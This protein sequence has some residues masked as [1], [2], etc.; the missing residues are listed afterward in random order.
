MSSR[1][2]HILFPSPSN[3]IVGVIGL[4][5][6]GL[7]VAC[8]FARQ[9]F[10]VIGLDIKADRVAKINAGI[11]PIEGDEPGLQALLCEVIVAQKLQA[12]T[13]Y[14]ELQAAHVITINVETPVDEFHVPQYHALRAAVH[15][16]GEV[17]QSDTLV[18][19]ESTV[20]P[21]TTLSLVKEILEESSNKKTITMDAQLQDIQ[22]QRLLLGMCPERV[23]PGRL[24]HNLRNLDRVC[25][26]VTP[27]VAAA[28][29]R[30]YRYIIP[31]ADLDATDILTAELV[32]TTE[33][34]Y[35][36]VQIAFANEVALICEAS[37][38]NVWKVRELVNKSP[39]RHML[40]PGAGVGGHCIPKDPWLLVNSVQRTKTA[41]FTPT[42]IPAARYINEAMPHHLYN[43]ILQRLSQNNLQPQ[44]A[45]VL[46]MGYSY[47][48]DSDDT[49]DT[50]SQKLV[51]FLNS[52]GAKITVHDPFVKPYDN[53]IYDCAL[54]CDIAVLMV[55]HTTYL[56]LDLSY[57][58]TM[59]RRRI[60]IDGRNAFDET[61]LNKLSADYYCIGVG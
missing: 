34:A 35:R 49:R 55:K 14:K 42:L 26:G 29:S 30:F 61:I 1:L 12:T 41:S 28:M 39:G 48:E 47:L 27:V 32:K 56:S 54:G 6:V 60:L 24:L 59:M 58:F 16:L 36:D 3:T 57:L 15:S 43:I 11:N 31:H 23:M 9:G 51:Y 18:I 21:G 7:P 46:I 40:L 2:D 4:G 22:M 50:P 53:D 25:G 52:V 13:D 38:G 44:D 8:E 20:A 5:Y 17:I 10:N 45:K 37:G 19:V 33:N